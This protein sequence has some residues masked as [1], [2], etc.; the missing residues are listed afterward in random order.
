[1]FLVKLTDFHTDLNSKFIKAKLRYQG[2]LMIH[3]PES[4][5]P[6]EAS[7]HQMRLSKGVWNE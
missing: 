7:L 2:S 4:N 6:G 1:M 5:Q 3:E